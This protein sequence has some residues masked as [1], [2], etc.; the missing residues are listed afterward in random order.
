MS[1]RQ[2]ENEKIWGY[3]G[4]VFSYKHNHYFRLGSPQ[5][6]SVIRD[7]LTRDEEW[8]QRMD[9]MAKREGEWAKKIRTLLL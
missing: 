2:Q 5:A 4:S 8:Y 7:E 1:Q 6:F 3:Y 9:Y